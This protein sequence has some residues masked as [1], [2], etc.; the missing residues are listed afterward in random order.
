MKLEYKTKEVQY[1]NKNFDKIDA[2]FMEIKLLY[3]KYESLFFSKSQLYK[4]LKEDCISLLQP[5]LPVLP[6]P[7][8]S[9]PIMESKAV[10]PA[11]SLALAFRG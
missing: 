9:I 7:A 10:M 8:L 11:I 6:M 1:S 2:N 4:H 3:R 5:L